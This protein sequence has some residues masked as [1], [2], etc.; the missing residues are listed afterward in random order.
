[1]WDPETFVLHYIGHLL[2]PNCDKTK[3]ENLK[4]CALELT[5]MTK[6]FSKIIS[7]HVKEVSRI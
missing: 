2:K 1:M 5:D 3:Q 7:N 4:K 6:N